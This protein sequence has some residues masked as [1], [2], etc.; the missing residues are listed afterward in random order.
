MM[1]T[2]ICCLCGGMAESHVKY[3]NAAMGSLR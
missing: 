3:G 1:L 2:V